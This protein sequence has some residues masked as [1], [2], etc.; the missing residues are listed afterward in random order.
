MGNIRYTCGKPFE[1]AFVE[2]TDAWS[3]LEVRQAIDLK[4]EDYIHLLSK[5]IAEVYLPT[6][7]G[8]PIA[9]PKDYTADNIDRCD[10][11]LVT[12]LSGVPMK[13]LKD[14]TDMGEA[15]GAELFAIVEKTTDTL[16][17]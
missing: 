5:K 14:I 11:R 17:P 9:A 3:R 8:A 6:I 12:W 10:T 7:S 2:F 15:L 1:Q 13:V 4:G 16:A